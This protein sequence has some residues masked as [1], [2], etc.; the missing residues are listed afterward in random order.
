MKYFYTLFSLLF[1]MNGISQA[2]LNG[3]QAPVVSVQFINNA[4]HFE[5]SNPTTSN[6]YQESYL[7]F[8]PA[9]DTSAAD[10]HW[11]FQGYAIYQVVD[12]TVSITETE[13]FNFVRMVA[14][15]DLADGI[16]SLTY[17][18]DGC[19]TYQMSLI[20]NGTQSS[21]I[22]DTDVFSGS[23]FTPNETYCFRVYAFASNEFSID[24][25]CGNGPDQLRFGYISGQGTALETYC[26]VA[27]ETASLDETEQVS[28][29]ISPNPANNAITIEP[30]SQEAL[31]LI[32]T[33]LNGK[34]L[35]QFDNFGTSTLDISDIAA[36]HYL[37]HIKANGKLPSVERIVV[38][39]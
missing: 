20:D 31:E 27:S 2:A 25:A 17:T 18:F 39:H 4:F 6:N 14:L 30:A 37:L 28:V 15:S 26:V 12:N 13:D 38:N 32:I 36:G 3:P 5:L 34:Q 1:C 35:K 24:P 29:S 21:H 16:T 19:N 22:V 11:R 23:P 7:E 33:D 9:I 10:Q 8:D